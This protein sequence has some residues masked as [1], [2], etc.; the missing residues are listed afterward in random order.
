[1]SGI[2]TSSDPDDPDLEAAERALGLRARSAD[3]LP[4]AGEQAWADRFS[5]LWLD[6]QPRRPGAHVWT[7]I[8]RRL[9][10]LRDPSGASRRHRRLP[11]FLTGLLSGLAT[12]AALAAVAVLGPID[13]R[14]LV[15]GD[16]FVAILGPDTASPLFTAI[17]DT[18]RGTLTFAS[19]TG[20]L[21]GPRVPQLWYVRRN[22]PPLSLG[23]IDPRTRTEVT[24][25]APVL[26]AWQPGETLAVS[27]EPAGGSP[28]GAP[29]GPVIA[30]G[31]V[32]SLD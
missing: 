15:L 10:H 13:L 28:T 20:A 12:A 14:S 31:A 21:Q 32:R 22:G 17:V 1:M 23:L 6:V 8:A 26:R 25:P 9:A 7:G 27:L 3:A 11:A 24:V 16:K 2:G 29:T 5:P 18:R 30:T 4:D 19:V